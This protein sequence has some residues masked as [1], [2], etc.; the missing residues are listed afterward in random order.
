MLEEKYKKMKLACLCLWSPQMRAGQLVRED[1]VLP[2]VGAFALDRQWES[3]VAWFQIG[4]ALAYL[5][6]L[7]LSGWNR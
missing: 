6:Q 3:L 4:Q 2:P 1:S 7:Y 5:Q